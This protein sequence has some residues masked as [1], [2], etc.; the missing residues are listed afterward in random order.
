MMMIQCLQNFPDNFA[1]VFP[2]WCFIEKWKWNIC[3][4]RC[5]YYRF[6]LVVYFVTDVCDLSTHIPKGLDMALQW[7]HNERD[8]VSK[9]QPHDCS[10]N[11]LFRRRSKKT[12]KLRI[13]GLC[14]GNSPATGEF[15]AQR[16]S[17][18]ENVSIW[19]H[20]HG[21]KYVCLIITK[22]DK[23]QILCMIFGHISISLYILFT[24]VY[25]CNLLISHWL[26][27]KPWNH[28]MPG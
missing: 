15:P 13:T 2:H 8:G 21:K 19:W 28:K 1:F 4:W 3:D 12:S 26:D 18:A 6:S 10:P 16:A 27:V 22:H 20:H 25:N 5:F 7:R 14:E 9:H 17:N 23:A 24:W 11:H